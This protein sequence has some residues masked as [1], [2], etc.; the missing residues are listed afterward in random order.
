M[1]VF[2]EFKVNVDDSSL[3]ES[4]FWVDGMIQIS[5]VLFGGGVFNGDYILAVLFRQ[6]FEVGLARGGEKLFHVGLF[7]D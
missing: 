4:A 3:K 1:V 5:G 7:D 2:T 6:L